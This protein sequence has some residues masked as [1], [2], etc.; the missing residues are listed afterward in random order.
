MA[1]LQLLVFFALL[2][3][4][5]AWLDFY[6]I[7]K[8]QMPT[9]RG[10]VKKAFRAR[11]LEL[12]PDKND[13]PDAEARFRD[14]VDGM[15]VCCIPAYTCVCIRTEVLKCESVFA[16]VCAFLFLCVYVCGHVKLSVSFTIRQV[17]Y[18]SPRHFN[19]C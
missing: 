13:K 3:I 1:G 19:L 5:D 11:A 7:M 10:A 8:I 9:N 12:H 14:L 15:R 6:E 17:F 4:A 16:F 2:G 18:H